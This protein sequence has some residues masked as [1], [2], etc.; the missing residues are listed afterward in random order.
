[1]AN[2]PEADQGLLNRIN[3]SLQ[4][5]P[6][7]HYLSMHANSGDTA[8]VKQLSALA[9]S[10]GLPIPDNATWSPQANGFANTGGSIYTPL[11]IAA[12]VGGGMLTAGALAPLL[13]G[14]GGAAAAGG[15]SAAAPAIAGGSTLTLPALTGGGLA[16]DGLAAPSI[17]AAAGGGSTASLLGGLGKAATSLAS[18]AAQGRVAESTANQNQFGEQIK[19]LNAQLDRAS[20]AKQLQEQDYKDQLRGALLSNMQ[21]FQATPPPEVA[22]HMGTVTGGLRPSALGPGRAD[23]GTNM[24]NTATLD[25][26]QKG[27]PNTGYTAAS[28]APMPTLPALPSPGAGTT[29]LGAL[30]PGLSIASLLATK[31]PSLFGGK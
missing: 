20:V 25:L 15:A 28:T 11:K 8:A 30:G 31:Y 5:D 9:A 22:S 4:A 18:G 26:L 14:A 29:A 24:T 6:Q 7:W 23:L 10:K 19:G 16:I 1:M 21:D 17:A 27:D 13:A 12:L 2:L 3:T